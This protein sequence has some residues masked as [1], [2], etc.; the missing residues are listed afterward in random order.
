VALLA[1]RHHNPTLGNIPVVA[2]STTG[3]AVRSLA[4]A[5]GAEDFLDQPMNGE[6]LLAVIGR[7]SGQP[8]C[9]KGLQIRVA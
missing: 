3:R 8:V 6:D 9:G 1:A 2:L 5:L 7:Y 4:L